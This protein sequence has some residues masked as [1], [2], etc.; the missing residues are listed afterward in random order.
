MYMGK[1]IATVRRLYAVPF[2]KGN[3]YADNW[4]TYNPDVRFAVVFV[5]DQG[6]HFLIAGHATEAGAIRL[7]DSRHIIDAVR[8]Y[9]GVVTYI[10]ERAEGPV[11]LIAA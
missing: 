9:D 3:G 1:G 8:E 5:D 6:S 2:V 11:N 4:N 10:V 7:K